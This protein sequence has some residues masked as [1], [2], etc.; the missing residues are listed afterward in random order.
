ME[1]LVLIYFLLF[2]LSLAAYVLSSYAF[3]VMAQKAGVKHAWLSWIPIGNMWIFGE[4]I[5]QKLGKN[6]GWKVVLATIVYIVAISIQSDIIAGIFA[7][8]FTIFSIVITYWLFKK[9]SEKPVL[10]TVLS[11]LIPF[12]YPIVLSVVMKNKPKDI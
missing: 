8:I 4:L 5:S 11:V 3:M 7:L 2:I 1:A 12:Y 9:Y 6:A 10:H